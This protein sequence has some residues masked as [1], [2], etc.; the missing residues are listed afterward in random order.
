M[1][2]AWEHVV[3]GL[4]LALFAYGQYAGLYMSPD[5]TEMGTVVRLLYVHVPAAWVSMIAFGCAFLGALGWLFTSRRGFDWLAESGSEVGV[6]MGVILC[7]DG[8]FFARPTFNAW[9]PWDARLTTTAIMILSFVGVMTLRSV[10]DDPDRRAT[11]SAV[12]TV[13]AFANVPITYFSVV[14]FRSIHQMQST[15]QTMDK[16]I[17]WVFELNVLAFTLIGTWMLVRRW[18]IAKERDLAQQPPPL[19]E[20]A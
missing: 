12:A 15:P 11:W 8:S 6:L 14:W 10:L 3:G 19:P 17:L 20:A 1:K 18:R 2:L 4:G 5:S 16:P 7:I 13:F 9:W